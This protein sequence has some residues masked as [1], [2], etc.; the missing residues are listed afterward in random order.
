MSSNRIENIALHI[1]R[2]LARRPGISEGRGASVQSLRHWWTISLGQRREDF[3]RGLEYAGNCSWIER[4][5]DSTVVLTNRG[6]E[7]CGIVSLGSRSN[8]STEV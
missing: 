5:A 2:H 8:V 4:G 3:E 6:S 7:K 1:L